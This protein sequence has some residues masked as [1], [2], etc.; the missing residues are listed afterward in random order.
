MAVAAVAVAAVEAA[1][2]ARGRAVAVRARLSMI[3]VQAGAIV[4]IAGWLDEA[5]RLERS[6]ETDRVE[7]TRVARRAAVAGREEEAAVGQLRPRPRRAV[8]AALVEAVAR[9]DLLELVLRGLVLSGAGRD[10]VGLRIVG[11]ARTGELRL[12]CDGARRKRGRGAAG[13]ARAL[14]D[15]S[16]TVS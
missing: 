2:E 3:I 9:V 13:V 4:P 11:A 5:W 16:V 10:G 6:A 7:H 1:V 15:V 14:A 8:V 12:V